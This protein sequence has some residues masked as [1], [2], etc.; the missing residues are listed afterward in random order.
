MEDFLDKVYRAVSTHIIFVQQIIS[1]HEQIDNDRNDI[2]DLYNQLETKLFRL[3]CRVNILIESEGV[4]ITN[5]VDAS[6]IPDSFESENDTVYHM[7]NYVV[8]NNVKTFLD[9]LKS[10]YLTLLADNDA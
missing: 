7:R 8:G 1:E 9:S 2:G 10:N 5:F 6:V 4:T 3:L